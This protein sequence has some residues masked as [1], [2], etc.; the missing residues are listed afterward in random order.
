MLLLTLLFVYKDKCIMCAH[1]CTFILLCFSMCEGEHCVV[2]YGCI[3]MYKGMTAVSGAGRKKE[4]FV[5]G[6]LGF[7]LQSCASSFI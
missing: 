7:S 6:K 5:F 4:C 3:S 1:M 2:L